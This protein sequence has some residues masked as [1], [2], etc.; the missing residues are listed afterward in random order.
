MCARENMNSVAREKT[1]G[2]QWLK[3]SIILG[4]K[5]GSGAL[6]KLVVKS[7]ASCGCG[8]GGIRAYLDE[9]PQEWLLKFKRGYHLLEA[10]YVTWGQTGT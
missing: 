5:E 6:G 2:L 1:D 3:G 9:G 7:P 10:A 8:T 4:T